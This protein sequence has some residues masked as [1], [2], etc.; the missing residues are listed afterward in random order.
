[1]CCDELFP[2]RLDFVILSIDLKLQ[3]T[4]VRCHALELLVLIAECAVQLISLQGLLFVSLGH[5]ENSLLRECQVLTEV[6]GNGGVPH[7][8]A[9]LKQVLLQLGPRS[10][11]VKLAAQR[12][13]QLVGKDAVVQPWLFRAC[14]CRR[15]D[16]FST[17]RLV[18]RSANHVDKFANQLDCCSKA[19]PELI[20]CLHHVP[21]RLSQVPYHPHDIQHR[22]VSRGGIRRQIRH[23][24]MEH[25]KHPSPP[26]PGAAV[27]N[28]GGTRSSPDGPLNPHNLLNKF[29]RITGALGNSMIGPPGEVQLDHIVCTRFG[30]DSEPPFNPQFV[31][32]DSV[33]HNTHSGATIVSLEEQRS[34]WGWPVLFTLELVVLDAPRQHSDG[35]TLV[36]GDGLPKVS[37]RLR[38]GT[39][40]SEVRRRSRQQVVYKRRVQVPRI[41]IERH[42]KLVVRKYVLVPVA[43]RPGHRHLAQ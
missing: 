2:E 18:R 31:F 14:L 26:D 30:H 42:A 19:E 15:R 28:E 20:D 21:T 1:M 12:L 3:V 27:H 5:K 39:L 25:R 34:P 17:R 35:H 22:R 13:L 4:E 29:D 23:D 10:V 40:G 37:H 6:G 16:S 32:H 11:C 9:E 36:F 41:A 8:R 7:T 24:R 33:A 43:L 38:L